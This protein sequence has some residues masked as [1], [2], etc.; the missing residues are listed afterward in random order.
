MIVNV[1]GKHDTTLWAAA[2]L[3]GAELFFRGGKDYVVTVYQNGYLI[4]K[5]CEGRD[6]REWVKWFRSLK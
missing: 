6:S 4:G 1:Y 5:T 2:D 3:V